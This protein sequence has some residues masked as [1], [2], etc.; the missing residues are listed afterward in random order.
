MSFGISPYLQ[1]LK[2]VAFDTETTGLWAGSHRLVEIGAVEFRLD[3]WSGA[4][5]ESLINPEKPIPPEARAVHGI[6]DQMVKSAPP[7]DEVLLRF[8]EFCGPDAVLVAHNAPFD[9]SF[10]V[11]EMDRAGLIRPHL[12]VLD[13][14]DMIRRTQP[15]LPSY[16]LVNLIEHFELGAGQ[17]H[18]ALSDAEYVRQLTVKAFS[19]LGRIES[20]AAL[21][22]AVTVC[23]L[24]QWSHDPVDLPDRFEPLQKAIA[25]G[26]RIKMQ[27]C[28]PAT[29][30]SWRVVRPMQVY[31]L[32]GRAYL[33]AWCEQA[34]QE[35]TF[36]LDR[37]LS[38]E[39][40]PERH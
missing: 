29:E 6:T 32:T 4:R 25:D 30:P 34:N 35:R 33:N 14:V 28:K 7:A 31:G 20:L 36:R 10:L 26:L 5:F 13:T 19:K 17:E 40:L 2:L 18:R 39:I 11:S 3:G 21:S 15:G 23:D 24:S 16:A 38:F 12:L 8:F 9:I 27:Y 37:V 1:S 22:D